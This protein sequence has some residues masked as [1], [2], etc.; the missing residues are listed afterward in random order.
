MSLTN[1]VSLSNP[2]GITLD[3]TGNIVINHLSNNGWYISKVSPSGFLLK[4]T[5][6]GSFFS[7]EDYGS[8]ATI[9][10]TG[11][12]LQLRP[13]GD[14]VFIDSDSLLLTPIFKIKALNNIDTSSA[15]DILTGGINNKI[16]IL[17]NAPQT[18][19][20][21]IAILER[22]NQLDIFITAKSGGVF[23]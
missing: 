6:Y 9:P 12:I 2:A 14:L 21:D 17:P 8:L 20:G 4:Q 18:V 11:N 10:S 22:N 19:Y 16:S 3:K 23:P 1:F 5:E 15:Y 13:N 7:I